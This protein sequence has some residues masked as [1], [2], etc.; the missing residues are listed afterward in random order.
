VSTAVLSASHELAQVGTP[1]MLNARAC[2]G[3]RCGL[4]V[5]S[6]CSA[7]P[8]LLSLLSSS[9][10]VLRLPT[11]PGRHSLVVKFTHGNNKPLGPN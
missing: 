9:S 2:P 11:L 7:Q 3:L 1:L 10:M 4:A 6:T 8:L 5:W